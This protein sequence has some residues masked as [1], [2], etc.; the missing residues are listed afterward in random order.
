MFGSN[1]NLRGISEQ[2]LQVSQCIH[3]QKKDSK[4]LGDREGQSQNKKKYGQVYLA[5]EQLL[6]VSQGGIV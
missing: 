6:A 2:P 1:A 5:R 4:R 3:R